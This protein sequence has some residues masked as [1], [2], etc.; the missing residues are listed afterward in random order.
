MVLAAAITEGVKAWLDEFPGQECT[1]LNGREG[2]LQ[3]IMTHSHS[4][5]T[6]ES[7][8]RCLTGQLC[9]Y[10]GI[11]HPY[12]TNHAYHPKL[13][14]APAKSSVEEQKKS[15]AI[16]NP[17]KTMRLKTA[18]YE[19]AVKWHNENSNNDKALSYSEVEEVVENIISSVKIGGEFLH[20]LIHDES[21]SMYVGLTKRGLPEEDLRWL[22]AR[23]FNLQEGRP[24]R[25]QRC[26][27][28]L[29][30]NDNES[31]E[32]TMNQ[33][34]YYLGFLSEIV[35]ESGVLLNASRVEDAIQTKFD[36]LPLG[37][38]LWRCVAKGKSSDKKDATEPKE[39][40]KVFI[41]YST[42]VVDLLNKK[43]IKIQ[44]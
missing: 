10:R 14:E 6:I 42:K 19:A 24:Y 7:A 34:R 29:L 18:R 17:I 5:R 40:Y 21:F 23:G 4:P 20:A 39:V 32:I 27:P 41:T 16:W 9:R 3:L 2:L 22:T 38:K 37:R 31:S 36:D 1:K 11:I 44:H 43:Q 30:W 15:N 33:G 8:Q 13:L 28:V 26:R 12:K 25:G 35:Y